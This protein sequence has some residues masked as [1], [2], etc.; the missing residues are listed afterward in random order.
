M[1]C[2]LLVVVVGGMVLS[3]SAP[4]GAGEPKTADEIIAEY[5]E[6]VG[7]RARIDSVQSLR[8]TGK[9]V[10]LGGE[11]AMMAVYQRPNKLR[12]E[13]INQGVTSI[14][15]FDGEVAWSVNP[16]MGRPAPQKLPPDQAKVVSQQADIDGPLID[17]RK[18]GHQ[19][20]LLGKEEF[21][22]SEVYQ[23]KLTKKSGE[24]EYHYLDAERFLPVRI[25]G[26]HAF[27]NLPGKYDVAYG[28]YRAVDGLLIAHKV[29]QGGSG[30]KND[31]IYD[32][33]E[34]NVKV[35]DD[36]FALPPDAKDPLPT[37]APPVPKP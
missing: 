18:K 15:A 11:I 23:L 27:E 19:V 31:I 16:F 33:V 21:K 22:G 7:G 8:M 9:N 25:T 3:G 37:K 12:I 5:I 6:A 28:D 35:P 24:V 4:V 20:E 36:Y 2:S 13:F 26:E 14:H 32:K 17:Y 1:R 34:I 30:A 10:H 29:E